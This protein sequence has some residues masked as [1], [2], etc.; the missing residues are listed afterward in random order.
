[1]LSSKPGASPAL[2]IK[3]PADEFVRSLVARADIDIEVVDN[4]PY[5]FEELELRK[6]EVHRAL[7]TQGFLY[8]STGLSITDGGRITAEV[9]RQ[10]GLSDDTA[11]I[12][13]GLSPQ[14]RASVGLTVSDAPIAADEHAYGGMWVRDDG[15]NEC[16]SGWSVWNITSGTTGVTT[17]G[18]CD[19]INQVSEPGWGVWALTQQ[20]EHRVSGATSSGIHRVI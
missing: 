4:Q 12:L 19:G 20:A 5:S 9:T 14:L 10:S 16:T 15:V 1:V 8:I 18:H 7:E 13:S 3:G 11:V 2:Y 17:A 6:L